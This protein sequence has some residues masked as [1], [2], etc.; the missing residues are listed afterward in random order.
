MEDIVLI[1]VIN[2]NKKVFYF[3][4]WGR[5]FDR[6]NE[7]SLINLIRPNLTKFRIKNVSS[8]KICDS[9]YEGSKSK[10]F[11]ENFFKM[12]QSRIPFGKEYKV[13]QKTM[14]KKINEGKELYFL[15]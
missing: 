1:K 6:T 9:L 10:Y 13:W 7:D 8:I 3:L 12:C 5:V 15:G 11:Y 4:T 2:K 14:S